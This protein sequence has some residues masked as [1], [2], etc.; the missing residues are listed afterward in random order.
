MRLGNP[1]ILFLSARQVWVGAGL[2]RRFASEACWANNTR[3][4]RRRCR[5][6]AAFKW[7]DG[8]HDDFD[9]GQCALDFTLHAL[10]LSIKESLHFLEFG[11]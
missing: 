1:R 8:F 4:C 3:V 6:S 5:H 2:F 7:R 9:S 10:N 11:R